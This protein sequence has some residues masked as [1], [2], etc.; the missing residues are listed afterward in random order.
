MDYDEME[1]K[2]RKLER[3]LKLGLYV[4]VGLMVAAKV[5]PIFWR[6]IFANI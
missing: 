6:I 4:V 3:W 1:Q 2:G 5:V